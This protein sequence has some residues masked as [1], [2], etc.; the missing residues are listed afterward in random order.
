RELGGLGAAQRRRRASAGDPQQDREVRRQAGPAGGQG[1][2]FRGGGQPADRGGAAPVRH[3]HRL[4]ALAPPFPSRAGATV[5]PTRRS[6]PRSGIPVSVPP[7]APSSK[8]SLAR[9]IES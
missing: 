3:G 2:D 4:T 9:S 5:P 7:V 6:H 1:T 8:L